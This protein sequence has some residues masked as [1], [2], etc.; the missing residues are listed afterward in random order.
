MI[1]LLILSI[2]AV[3]ATDASAQASVVAE[4]KRQM[5]LDRNLS[6]TQINQLL[7]EVA[8]KVRGGI[9]V[10]TTGNQCLGY[11]CDIICFEGQPTMFDVLGSS[12]TDAIPQW[13]P[14]PYNGSK[15]EMITGGEPP[16]DPGNG[17][18]GGGQPPD[19]TMLLLKLISTMEEIKAD[20][21][22]QTETLKVAIEALK[23]EVAKGIKVRW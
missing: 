6:P 15:C 4:T 7:R 2:V 20:Q 13:N 8:R 1:A 3:T 21:Q 11:S 14:T 18:G 10:K 9:L 17:G 23:A 16:P 19:Q 5:Q 22:K 12:E